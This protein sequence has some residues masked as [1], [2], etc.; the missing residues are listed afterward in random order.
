[1]RLIR[2]VVASL[3]MVLSLPAQLAT[4][5]VAGIVLNPEGGMVCVRGVLQ[6]LLPGV[7]VELPANAAGPIV[8]ASFGANGGAVKTNSQLLILDSQ[9]QVQAQTGVPTGAA[10][11]GYGPDG[12][13]SWVYYASATR[14]EALDGSFRLSTAQL[15][16]EVVALGVLQGNSA[17]ILTRTGSQLWAETVDVTSGAIR[18]QTPLP[19]SSP[20]IYFQGDWLVSQPPG[21][22]WGTRQIPVPTEVTSL[23]A[24][25]QNSVAIDGGAWLLN[26]AWKILEIPGIQR[27][28]DF[29]RLKPVGS[30]R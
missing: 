22:L 18:S 7:P 27:P 28:H 16:D 11:F 5:P 10:L 8:S 21:L 13:I 3:S 14:M 2:L 26:G 25:S 9:N 20:A 15:G 17:G 30:P 12:S 29:Q 24:A 23:Q 19:G 1:M 6:T 4:Q